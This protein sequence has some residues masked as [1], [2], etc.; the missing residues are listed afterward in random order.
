MKNIR[1][2]VSIIFI[3]IG[4]IGAIFTV[5][6][7]LLTQ[8]VQY[9]YTVENDHINTIFI[10]D[11]V[12][13]IEI[14]PATGSNIVVEW[15]EDGN[16]R[17]DRVT[18][19]ESGNQLEVKRQR[20]LALLRIPTLNMTPKKMKVYVPKDNTSS[21]NIQNAVGSVVV[22]DVHVDELSVQTDVQKIEIINVH[23]NMIEALSSVGSIVIERSTGDIT[24]ISNVGSVD[25]DL[26]RV[27]GDMHLQSDVG[28]VK[29]GLD[30]QPEDVSFIGSSSLGSVKIFGEKTSIPATNARYEVYLETD[31]G[32]VKVHSRK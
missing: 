13:S 15:E 4:I 10:K 27:T 26:E 3:V 22:E 2:I 21:I 6:D 11:R 32:S 18:I 5:K 25:V 16:R 8:N 31:V 29:L 19:D 23:G 17:S 30:T 9:E 24:A 7:Y 12:A 28:S 1:I 14:V 20:T